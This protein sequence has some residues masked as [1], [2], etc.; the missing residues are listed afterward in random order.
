MKKML[1]L[2][3]SIASVCV[4]PALLTAEIEFTEH[5]LAD[6]V[7]GPRCLFAS[8]IDSDGDM[9]LVAAFYSPS[10]VIWFENE[11]EVEFTE[12][13]IDD[14]FPGALTVSAADLDGDDDIDIIATGYSDSTVGWYE[15]DGDQEFE[16]HFITTIIPNP[17]GLCTADIDGD[18][19]IDI[20]I[21]SNQ[22]NAAYLWT[23]DG[24]G[25]FEEHLV[26]TSTGLLSIYA[27][28]VDSDDDMDIFTASMGNN[29]ME[30][31]ENDG[32]LNFELHIVG[33]NF[34][35]ARNVFAADVDSDGD[36][37]VLGAATNGDDIA[38]YSNNGNEVFTQNLINGNFDGAYC[39]H[40]ADLDDDGDIDVMGAAY[41]ANDVTWW[42]N[43]GD[44][45]FTEYTLNA[46]VSGASWVI[47]ADMDGDD[48]LDVVAAATNGDEILWWEH[49]QPDASVS[50][51]IT[52]SET[53]DPVADALVA[54]GRYE[55]TTD[56]NGD[57]AFEEFYSSVYD[58][59][60]VTEGYFDY[61]E[62]DVEVEIGENEFDFIIDILSGDLTGIVTD[63]L[64]G[65]TLTGAAVTVTDPETG[66]PYREV[67]TDEFGEYEAEA[68][69]DG[70]RYLVHVLLAGYANSDTEDV[71]I[72]WDRD[73]EQDFE[74][75]PIF[76]RNIEQLQTEQDPDTWVR[77]TGIVTQG[78]NIT[79]IEHTEFYVQDE[80]G[81]GIQVYGTNPWDPENNIDRGDE[82]NIVGYLVEVDDVTRITNFELEVIGNDNAMPDPMIETTGNMSQ[83]SEREGTW[84]QMSGQMGRTPPDEGTYN[85]TINDGSGQC[86]V[87]I[88]ETTGID[89]TDM[90]E[91]DWGT[92]RGVIGLSRQGLRIIPNM[93]ED[94]D[95][96][97]VNPP[98]D[99]SA[100]TEEI[101]GDTL[102]LE[103]TLSWSHDHLDEWQRFK[104]YRNGEH[105]GNSQESTWTD[106]LLDPN[107]GDEGSYTWFYTISAVYDVGE[108][109]PSNE[110]E[111]TW[112][113]SSIPEKHWSGIP[114]TWSLEAVYPNPFNLTLN[115]VLGLPEQSLLKVTITNL[116]GEETGVLTDGL[117]KPGYHSFTFDATSHAS[118]IYFIH[119]IVPGRLDEV[120]KIV[121]MK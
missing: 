96:L 85:L 62:D 52:D 39:V 78:T 2:F 30:W 15:N 76:E 97:E 118:G 27:T 55:A 21:A 105:V 34:Q 102:Q 95:R 91:G 66:E 51:N 81:W 50:G 108:S 99:L 6:G 79:D 33:T 104:I 13:V 22:G 48:D 35:Q 10:D 98:T 100:A 25:N 5:T 70:V 26:G 64:T 31:W 120:R 36:M 1:K 109:S 111:V 65:E 57:Y 54:F 7:D 8:D 94:I 61:E 14:E 88:I 53:G 103:V 90:T 63:A 74:L 18:D 23:N 112:D 121:L 72:R 12:H 29:R 115:V 24:E 19:D 38:W 42:E 41:N 49:L 11:G 80:T 17:H 86:D 84:A 59:I 92:F 82:I 113:I 71:M 56:E 89:L 83:A 106:T 20:M 67:E 40:A 46:D 45:T 28:D 117:Y 110:V 114:E 107:P 68:L 73:N 43:D 119:A 3:L 101:Q 69:H 37:D 77:T 16:L 4:F 47:A 32:E 116:L 9:D 93:G 60:I 44:E 75:T 87:R 58:V